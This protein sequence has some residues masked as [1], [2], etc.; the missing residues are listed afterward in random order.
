[1]FLVVFCAYLEVALR[2]SASR[3]NVRGFCTDDDMTAI[4]AFP[5]FDFAFFKNGS[6]FHV[7]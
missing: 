7:L 1:M 3:A 4:S 5:D 2:V 6:R